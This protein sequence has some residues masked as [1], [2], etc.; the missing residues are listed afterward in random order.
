MAALI[1]ALLKIAGGPALVLVLRK[2]APEWIKRLPPAVQPVFAAL[3][4]V[5]VALGTGADPVASIAMLI[6]VCKSFIAGMGVIK[7]GDVFTGNA[8]T[9]TA[10]EKEMIRDL[11]KEND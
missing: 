1:I 10:A 4:N 2:L 8:A 3:V 7:T 9:V 11:P 5:L 6:E